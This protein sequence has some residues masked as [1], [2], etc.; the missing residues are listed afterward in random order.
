MSIDLGQSERSIT[1]AGEGLKD[2]WKSQDS[3]HVSVGIRVISRA[4]QHYRAWE[5]NLSGKTCRKRAAGACPGS[6]DWGH[7]V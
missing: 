7:K 3:C 2:Q 1:F 6:G 4:P 5:I